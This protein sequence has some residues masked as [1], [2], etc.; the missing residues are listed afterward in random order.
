LRALE[1]TAPIGH[2]RDRILSTVIEER[3]AQLGDTP[4]LLSDRE[5]LTYRELS[6]RIHQYAR[7]ALHRGIDKGKVVGLLMGNGPE[8]LAIW[9]GITSVGGVVSL[10]NTNLPGPSL[11]HCVNVVSPR[12]LIVSAEL[13]GQLGALLPRLSSA[14]T[15]WIHGCDTDT[16]R[17]IDT[18]IERQSGE[19]LS[20]HEHRP[21]TIEDRALFIYTSGT[22]GPPKA[23]NISHARVMQWGHWFAGMMGAHQLTECITASPCITVLAGCK[24]LVRS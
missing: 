7:W 19:P 9:L 14:P 5:C 18:E 1:L 3:A 17:R 24:C 2:N 13:A 15:I 6:Q 4:A 16:Y 11:A 20:G 22:T 21:P 10:L 12:H 8:Y 23:A